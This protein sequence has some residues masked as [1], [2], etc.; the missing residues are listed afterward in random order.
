ATANNDLERIGDI[1][2]R[3]GIDPQL[4]RDKLLRDKAVEPY[5]LRIGAIPV[6]ENTRGRRRGPVV[7]VSDKILLTVHDASR[8]LVFALKKCKRTG[9]MHAHIVMFAF[10]IVA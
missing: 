7:T 3:C 2:T 1:K 5:R 10:G 8:Q 6:V 9:D 4:C